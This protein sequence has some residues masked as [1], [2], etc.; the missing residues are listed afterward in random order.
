M[1]TN[2]SESIIIK[3]LRN[4]LTWVGIVVFI[5]MAVFGIMETVDRDIYTTGVITDYQTC[6][7]TGVCVGFSYIVDD[8]T[9]QGHGTPSRGL[10]ACENTQWCVGK[11]YRVKYSSKKPENSVILLNEPADG[12]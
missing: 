1:I 2:V 3:Q 10:K 4:P 11:K 5:V 12:S 9:Y 7:V 6:A 8:K